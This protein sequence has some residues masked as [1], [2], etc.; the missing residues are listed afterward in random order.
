M[1][2]SELGE[3]GLIRR[4]T[5]N[6]ECKNSSTLKGVGDDCA[7]IVPEE[8]M[9]TV[10]TLARNMTFLMKSIK[11]GLDAYGLP[12]KEEAVIL[13]RAMENYF[14]LLSSRTVRCHLDKS[15]HSRYASRTTFYPLG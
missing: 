15:W 11:L 7:V 8:G 10:R 13:K 1:E 14:D 2:I 12:E 9:Q 4:L 6:L 5:E 3:F